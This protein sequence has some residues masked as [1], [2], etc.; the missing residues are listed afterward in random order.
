MSMPYLKKVNGQYEVTF[1]GRNGEPAA[2]TKINLHFKHRLQG[3]KPLTH[4]L[5]TDKQGKIKLGSL[6]DVSSLIA[7]VS[8]N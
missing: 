2:K 1:L 5:I 7:K 8:N 4:T 3:K 6:T